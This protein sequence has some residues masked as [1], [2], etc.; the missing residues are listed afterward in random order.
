MTHYLGETFLYL[1]LHKW[2][3]FQQERWLKFP[4]EVAFHSGRN[5]MPCFNA[6]YLPIQCNI[7]Q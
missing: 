4:T 1:I 5:L 6:L 7:N 3:L 2:G